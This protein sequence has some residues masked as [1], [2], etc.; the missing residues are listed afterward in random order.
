MQLDENIL[1]K[2]EYAKA[3]KGKRHFKDESV[4]LIV[5]ERAA[6][7]RER[8]EWTTAASP[9]SQSYRAAFNVSRLRQGYRSDRRACASTEP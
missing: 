4:S 5:L 8:F 2:D 7:G 3:T 6:L 1:S 9:D